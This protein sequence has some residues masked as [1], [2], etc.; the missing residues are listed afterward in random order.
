LVVQIDNRSAHNA[1]GTK[2][3][4]EHNPLKRLPQ[5]RDSP[6]IS[7]SD[8]YLFAKVKN[9]LIRS[10]IPDEIGLFEAVTKIAGCL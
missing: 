1:S 9:A 7:V 6:Y 3:F 10:E 4:V 2:N 8:F 5:P